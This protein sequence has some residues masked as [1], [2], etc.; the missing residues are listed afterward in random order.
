ME[1]FRIVKPDDLERR[2]RK[3]RAV[4]LAKFSR[5]FAGPNHHMVCRAFC[6][7]TVLM[8]LEII[9]VG[10]FRSCVWNTHAHALALTAGRQKGQ[11]AKASLNHIGLPLGWHIL[12]ENAGLHGYSSY[13]MLNTALNAELTTTDISAMPLPVPACVLSTFV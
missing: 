1:G 9:R 7:A 2:D 3:Y 4:A 8:P 6:A 11:G 10:R 12:P 13:S 5:L